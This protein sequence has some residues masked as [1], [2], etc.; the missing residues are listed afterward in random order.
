[1]CILDASFLALGEALKVCS[2][3]M[4]EGFGVDSEVLTPEEKKNGPF[5]S[6]L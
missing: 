2:G 6:I 4:G 3:L 1:L 5:F